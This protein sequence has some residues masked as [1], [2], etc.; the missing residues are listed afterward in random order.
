V[1]ALIRVVGLGVRFRFDRQGRPVT[2][3][4]AR[5]RRGCT[6][7]WGLR[8]LD[9]EVRPGQCMALVGPN[10]AGKTTLLR[11][12]A[13]V[14]VADEGRLEVN[15]RL[16]TLLS[17]QAG[18][19]PPLTG[20][21]SCRLLCA[22]AGVP[23]AR[24]RSLLPRL[25]VVSGLAQAFD[26]PVSSYSQG[27]RARLGFATIAHT[28][29][30]ILLLDEVHEALDRDFRDQLEGE[31]RRITEAGGIVLTAGHDHE[32]LERLAPRAV[33]LENGSV[34]AE[35][36]FAEVANAYFREGVPGAATGMS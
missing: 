17:V 16:G 23:R 20:R 12:I 11:A 30:E 8:D 31:V 1:S 28:E 36:S 32:G 4:A 9:L 13:G 27:M 2:P 24:I 3:A 34:I 5:I 6:S 22:L 29:P 7:A 26:R 15:G 18:L 35:G 10:G 33:V 25:Q 14:L 21:E 19:I